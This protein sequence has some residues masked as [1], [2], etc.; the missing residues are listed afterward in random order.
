LHRLPRADPAGAPEGCALRDALRELRGRGRAV[1][2]EITVEELPRWMPVLSVALSC[3][4][5]PM[6]GWA[7]WSA[8][9]AFAPAEIVGRV[10]AIEQRLESLPDRDEI[11]RLLLQ[12]TELSGKLAVM[13]ERL[14]GTRDILVRV[15]SQARRHEQIFADAA[16]A[17]G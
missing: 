5:F 1:E 7:R 4:A 10:D 15:E 16:N 13:N 8:H 12:M 14:E 11:H 3:I 17:R 2:Q 9:Q 6:I